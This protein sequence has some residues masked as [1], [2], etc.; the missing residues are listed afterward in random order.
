MVSSAQATATGE[1]AW[2][3]MSNT[4]S[5]P[6][7]PKNGGAPAIDSPASSAAAAVIG[8]ARRKPASRWTL[9]SPVSWATVPAT[10]NSV[11]L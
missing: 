4:S 8:R 6:R 7:N 10:R 9:R 5:L 11:A 2:R 3:A 1:A